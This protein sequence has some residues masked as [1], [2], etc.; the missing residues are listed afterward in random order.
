VSIG[1]VGFG[2]AVQ[3][4]TAL[5]AA[6]DMACS[7]AKQRGRNRIEIYHPDDDELQRVRGEQ[8]WG[9]RVLDVLEGNRFA[10]FR[11]RI[12]ALNGDPRGD[13]YE[14]LLR[15]QAAMGWSAPGEFVAAAERYGLMAQVD[16][17][18]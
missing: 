12:V 17:R 16:R 4:F 1:L 9:A 5:L 8:S 7:N 14:V 3:D 10:L 2:D 6:A 13:H 18:V 11:Q 15:P